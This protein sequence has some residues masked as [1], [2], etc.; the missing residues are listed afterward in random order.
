MMLIQ[1]MAYSALLAS[2]VYGG[3]LAMERVV[4]IWNGGQRTRWR[5]LDLDGASFLVT[6]NL[7]PAVIGL[8][9]PR[10]I[11]PEWALSLDEKARAL[12]LRH[13]I[14]HIR[15][16]DPLLLFVAAAAIA[17]FPWNVP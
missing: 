11:V 4:A 5:A 2:L 7:G 17:L 1:W 15:A 3:A 13:E 12:M 16:R 9:R 14:E 10:V 6:P 8:V